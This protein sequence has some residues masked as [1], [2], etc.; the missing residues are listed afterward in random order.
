[1]NKINWKEKDEKFPT[2]K[3][4]KTKISG[5]ISFGIWVEIDDNDLKGL[6]PIIETNH[7]WRKIEDFPPVGTEVLVKVLGIVR[8]NRNQ[9][10]F[11]LI[12]VL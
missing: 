3:V 5:H 6:I 8:D 4:I 1:M 9:V 7:E 11:R 12:E 10:W 2:D